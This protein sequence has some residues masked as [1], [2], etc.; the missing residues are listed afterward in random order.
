[1]RVEHEYHLV[2]P[3]GG[4]DVLIV[5]SLPEIVSNDDPNLYA[6]LFTGFTEGD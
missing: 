4:P 1:M 6:F 2:P 5:T 3:S